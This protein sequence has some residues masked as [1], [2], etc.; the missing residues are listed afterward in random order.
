MSQLQQQY[1]DAMGITV[2]QRREMPQPE[3]AEPVMP[4]HSPE[5]DDANS[6]ALPP[7]SE[8]NAASLQQAITQCQQCRLQCQPAAS[9][10]ACGSPQ[11]KLMVIG[12]GYG[13]AEARQGSLL[14]GEHGAML[15][16]MLTTIGIGVS[17]IY[18]TD[19]LKCRSEGQAATSTEMATCV[20]YLQRQIELSQP[21][22]LLV[23]GEQVA[24]QLLGSE[25]TLAS[26]R[27]QP[28]QYG[29][30]KLPLLVTFST[31]QLRQQPLNKRHAWQD[32][33][34]LRATLSQ[35]G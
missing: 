16:E 30:K 32:L 21:A 8:L 29:E 11:A 14:A 24:Q 9:L 13:E 27:Q 6:Q 23:M 26:L 33:C 4:S 15:A 17:Q 22:C 20:A 1:L 10:F 28:L 3:V 2:W 18:Y 5:P 34:H 25:Q 35:L 19:L 12:E 7:L 31:A